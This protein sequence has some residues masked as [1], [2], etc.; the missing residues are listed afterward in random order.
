MVSASSAPSST[1]SFPVSEP[2]SRNA[3]PVPH[4]RP[5][6]LPFRRISLP[7]APS[8][9]HRE[10]MISVASFDSLPEE[11]EPQGRSIPAV[12]MNVHPPKSGKG[13]PTSM[14]SPRRRR[15][16]DVHI[17][18]MDDARESKRRKIVEEFYETER[19][20]LDGL[21]LIYSH[22]LTPIIA[23]LDSPNPLLDR[24]SLTSVFSNFI[25]I[26]NLHRSFFSSLSTLLSNTGVPSS[27]STGNADHEPPH[28][29]SP[30]LLSHFPYLSLY[31]PFVTSFPSTIS[32]LADLITP[33]S[34]THANP[35]YNPPFAAFLSIQEADPR[36]A[37]LK[38]RDWLLT[39]V[40]RCPR[41]LLLLKDLISCTDP[42]DPEHGQLTAVHTLVSKITLSL[43][44][45]LH[46]HAQTLALLS[47]QRSTPNLPFQ[48]IA[49]GRTLLKRGP[50][51]QIERSAQPRE[52]EFLLFSDCL[53]WLANEEAERAW[54]GDWGISRSGW[55]AGYIGNGGP[56]DSP[57]SAA[58]SPSNRPQMLRTRSKSEAELSALMTQAGVAT[59][60]DADHDTESPSPSTPSTPSKYT[61]RNNAIRKSYHPPSN[62]IKRHPSSGGDERWV[63]KGRAELVDFE[64]VVTPPREQGEERRFEILSPEGSFVLYSSTEEERNEWCTA[65][66]QAKAQ[67]LVSLNITHPNST[68]TS[69]T[70]TNHL[71]RSL[72]ALPFPPSDERIATIRET[73]NNGKRFK[74]KGKKDAEPWERRHW[75]MHE[76]WEELWVEEKK[77][78]LSAVWATFFISDPNAKGDSSKPARACDA[79]YETV[80]PLIDPPPHTAD[81][82]DGPG[83]IHRKDVDALT[84]LNNLPSWLSMPSLPVSVSTTPQALMA[85]VREPSSPN[86]FLQDI[87]DL[88]PGEK[89]GRVKVRSA[90]NTRPKSYHHLLEDFEQSEH[91]RFDVLDVPLEEDGDG[92]EDGEG[93]FELGREPSYASSNG[94]PASSSSSPR[95]ENTARRNKRFS[96]PAVALH[97]TSVTARSSAVFEAVPA[98]TPGDGG[99]GPVKVNKRFSLVLG[100][101]RIHGSSGMRSHNEAV[102]KSGRV[103]SIAA[104]KLNELL[105]R[106]KV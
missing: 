55:G 57:V 48:L 12:I 101:S 99:S 49:P 89:R 32:A 25:D 17:K 38:L 106:G 87:P 73:G 66:R 8:K 93:R 31:N 14:E 39:I 97:T 91:G 81:T 29:L 41:Y 98:E 10:S 9:M 60:V 36:C 11:G 61:G 56:V 67:L 13:R 72:Q 78:P 35:Q 94:G 54:K 70:S 68:L 27:A 44:T 104:G 34:A 86:A 2:T 4:L 45:S 16:R 102:A 58:S 85:I 3:Q 62:L 5:P 83:T 52:R 59:V 42:E 88:A 28:P 82:I 7:T 46:T 96:L 18:P 76:V 30:I 80:F 40:Q 23:S 1:V 71:R 75:W 47:L 33:P 63:Y 100:G 19:A 65:I 77:A 84:S 74:G 43:N 24:S 90:Q 64:V 69:S 50:L 95:K 22:F 15:R 92:E 53:V 37:K 21:E 105:G 26:W 103:D 20:Y 79:C 6:H 51:L